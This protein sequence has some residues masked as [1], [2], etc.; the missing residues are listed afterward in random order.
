[1]SII[2]KIQAREILDSRGNPTIEVEVFTDN[3]R[4]GR[5]AVP[6]GASTGAH[7]AVELR[8]G[9]MKRY[10]GKGVLKAVANVNGALNDELSGVFVGDQAAIDRQMIALDGTANKANLGANAILG[11]SLAVAKVAASEAGLPLFRYVGG[12]NACTLPVPMMNILNGGAHADNKVDIQEFMVMPVGAPSFS[13]G[14]R[15]G[16]EVFHALKGVLKAQKLSTNV[17]DEGG[18]APDLKSNEDALKLVMQAIEKAGYRPGDDVVIALDAASTEFY[19]AKKERY[20]LESTGDSLGADDMVALWQDWSK[21]Y[22]IVSIED[23]MAED[24]WNGWKKLTKAIGG[25]VQL[26]GDDL[27][28]TNTSRLADGIE[29]N[30]ANSILVKVNQIGT[31]TETIEA[32]EMAHRAGYTTV[33]SHRSGET[34]DTTIADLAVAMN[35]GMIKTGSASRSDR[36]AKYNQLLRIEEQ[37]GDSARW[38]GKGL[39]YVG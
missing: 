19:D 17:G 5:A 8:D 3:G 16:T 37:L 30:I 2:A 12:I 10:A 33:M 22:P 15:M 23:G 1:M 27:F 28:V 7:E 32:V 39:K 6:S 29:K 31:L 11:V 4:I 21:R 24:D 34:E 25:K 26:V 36:I 13:E 20:V 35:C 18:F 9:D 38:P 14:L